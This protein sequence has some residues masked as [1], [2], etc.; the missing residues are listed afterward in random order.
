MNYQIRFLLF[1]FLFTGIYS[2]TDIKS[3]LIENDKNTLFE[4]LD[5]V[6]TQVTFVNKITTSD[7]LNILNFENIYLGGGI[8]IGDFNADGL[9]DLFLVGNMVPSKLYLNKGNFKFEDITIPS[10]IQVDGWVKQ[11]AVVTANSPPAQGGGQRIARSL[12]GRGVRQRDGSAAPEITAAG[13]GFAGDVGHGKGI[14]THR[15]RTLYP[16]PIFIYAPDIA[17]LKSVGKT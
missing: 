7:T 9:P 14:F 6:R 4:R 13:G 5:S 8:G 10:K 11:V 15:R 16:G 1:S 12:E 3:N 2:C 17:R